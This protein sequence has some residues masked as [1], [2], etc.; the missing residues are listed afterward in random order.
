M[1][2]ARL[3]LAGVA[4]AG[5]AWLSG[6]DSG[7][8]YPKAALAD[9]LQRILSKDRLEASVHYIDHTLG[10]QLSYPDVLEEVDG[11]LG[12][13]PGFEEAARKVLM[14]I[15]RVL[16][17]T[18][19]DVRFYVVL[20]SEPDVPGAYLTIV[21][22]MDDIRRAYAN[23]LDSPEMFARTIYDFNFLG[24]SPPVTIQQYVPR[25]IRLEE[26]LSWQLARRIQ[27]ALSEALESSG[28]VHVGRC[29][30]RFQDGEFVFTLDVSP[31]TP[32]G[33]VD[34]ATIGRAFEASTQVIANVLSSYRFESFDA[35]RLI[36]PLTGKSLVLPKTR[37]EIFR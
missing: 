3:A 28:S 23:M 21:R 2:R 16:L 14:A 36:H 27:S 19:A 4:L 26:F 31:V 6:C 34:E 11:Q 13:G 29:G 15:H 25:D 8:T 32:E 20:L 22:Y 17:S 7:P 18:D 24:G 12:I 30:G 9:S 5:A 35:I 1:P 37:L 10:V 33:Q